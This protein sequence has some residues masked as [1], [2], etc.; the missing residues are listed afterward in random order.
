MG[1]PC[2][3]GL[4]ACETGQTGARLSG[5]SLPVSD[6]TAGREGSP[7]GIAYVKT[8]WRYRTEWLS[9]SN[10]R[11]FKINQ[12]RTVRAWAPCPRVTKAPPGVS[13]RPNRRAT[14]N[15]APARYRRPWAEPQPA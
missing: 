6:I 3:R 5:A 11:S 9:Q 10:F 14:A 12:L 7:A 2:G 15:N 13:G 8:E 1:R 4:D